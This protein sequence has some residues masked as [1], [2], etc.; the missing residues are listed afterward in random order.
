MDLA[1]PTQVIAPTLDGVVLAVLARAGEG[2]TP[3]GVH[4]RC[5]RGS[6]PGV[7]R[8]LA[9]LVEQGIV[10]AVPAAN[11][12]LYSLNR[13]HL[14]GPL[15]EQLV[16]LRTALWARIR[17]HLAGWEI[18]AVHVSVFGSAARG[19][20]GASS[21]IDL[22]VVEPSKA[23]AS[24]ERWEEQIRALRDRIEAWTGNRAQVVELDRDELERA[25]RQGERLV[26]EI[27]RDGI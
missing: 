22:L 11:A 26:D 27:R 2:L 1:E 18:P 3:A 19:D 25:A 5:R 17:A 14:A 15:L 16:D 7:R 6:E 12:V 23:V 8:T 21:D 4:R 9:R 24:P 20:G 13:E 10:R